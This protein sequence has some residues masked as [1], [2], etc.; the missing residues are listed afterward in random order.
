MGY[1]L[2]NGTSGAEA[3][4]FS[5]YTAAGWTFG[6]SVGIDAT[7]GNLHR[8]SGAVGGNYSFLLA[9]GVLISP[10]L[11]TSARWLHFWFLPIGIANQAVVFLIGVNRQFTVLFNGSGQR[12]DLYLATGL[13]ASS[14]GGTWT[15]GV[16]HWLAIN[17]KADNAGTCEVFVDGVSVVA[18]SGD[19]QESASPDWDRFS[20]G[21]AFSVWPGMTG[22]VD[23]IICTDDDSGAMVLPLAE[24][25]LC[26]IFP[27]SVISGNLTGSSAT[28]PDRYQN[29]DEQPVN[30]ADYNEA[31]AVSDEDLYGLQNPP[32]FIGC[33]GV[34]V[35][36]EATRDGAITQ[37]ENH[38]VSGGSDTYDT[39]VVLPASPGY[40]VATTAMAR[41][42]DG[43][44]PWLIATVN[45]LQ[46]GARFS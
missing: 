13:V 41:N 5:S 16:G 37:V 44:V 33:H 42:P 26:P 35:Y 14:A 39:A 20:L 3:G 34:V 40:G 11:P 17:L 7:V 23:D 9:P 22:N 45:A 8:S 27:T 30:R 25:Y 31:A 32:S 36:S 2:L 38:I 1:Q 24:A 46:V 19:T 43:D 28:G 6:Y 12:V 18:Y 10:Y 21:D 4:V 29:V 15:Q